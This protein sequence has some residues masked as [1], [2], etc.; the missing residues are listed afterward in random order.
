MGFFVQKKYLSYWLPFAFII[1]IS[2]L[3][4]QK[5]PWLVQVDRQLSFGS[6]YYLKGKGGSTVKG[7]RNFLK[8][9]ES[10]S[11]Y[12][13]AQILTRPDSHMTILTSHSSDRLEL[14]SK[15]SIRISEKEENI[16][17]FYYMGE[18]YLSAHGERKDILYEVNLGE[19]YLE[20]WN[21][22]VLIRGKVNENLEVEVYRGKVKLKFFEKELEINTDEMAKY[23]N[24]KW[25]LVEKDMHIVTPKAYDRIY[26]PYN[27]GHSTRFSWSGDVGDVNE[28]QLYIGKEPKNLISV[29]ISNVDINS[30]EFA[31]H[32]P[33]GNYYWQLKLITPRRVFDSWIYKIFVLEEFPVQIMEPK[34][35][36][37]ANFYRNTNK[38]R[39]Q[40]ENP[41]RLDRLALEV[42]KTED[43]KELVLH[44]SVDKGGVAFYEF[45]WTGTFYWRVNGY[46]F[47]TSKIVLGRPEKFRVISKDAFLPIESIL[48]NN[49]D[50]VSF[51]DVKKGKILLRWNDNLGVKRYAVLL[52]GPDGYNKRLYT[53]VS[54]FP[55]PVLKAG[56]YS[57]QIV[58]YDVNDNANISK[59]FKFT[60]KNLKQISWKGIDKNIKEDRVIA[61]PQKI[62]K[63]VQWS[64]GPE[65]TDFYVFEFLES[66]KFTEV[67]KINTKKNYLILPKNINGFYKI[68]IKAHSLSGDLLAVSE[69]IKV[70]F[71]Q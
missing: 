22:D 10:S 30:H 64:K 12:Y 67:K 37:I 5:L 47:D 35:N 4:Y 23:S 18:L 19:S 14:G 8:V 24:G 36:R 52:K 15:T 51:N 11:I 6:I 17:F 60:I 21:A 20:V 49:G 7:S 45:P 42:S 70:Q 28:V 54:T 25:T 40:W 53:H 55:L 46:R 2:F 50:I 56:E 65:E 13:G 48:P 32:I 68:R 16:R 62:S 41:S 61:S 38:I 39:F 69:E 59:K 66:N 31:A 34:E 26:Y 44:E 1:I 9:Y 27:Q 29:P 43:F 3:S 63:M 58:S 57:W 33:K 71:I